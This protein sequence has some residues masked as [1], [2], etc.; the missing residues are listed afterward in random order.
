MDL[1]QSLNLKFVSDSF[2]RYQIKLE[3]CQCSIGID[4]FLTA[5]KPDNRMIRTPGGSANSCPPV[6]VAADEM[7]QMR[8]R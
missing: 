8:D 6:Q 3:G 4:Q 1:R 5:F 7:I 2:G